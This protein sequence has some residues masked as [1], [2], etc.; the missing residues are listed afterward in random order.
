MNR[1]PNDR[2]ILIT[3]SDQDF[4][5]VLNATDTAQRI[6]GVLPIEAE[7]N[8][9]G[10]EIYF[11]TGVQATK[12]DV[13]QQDMEVGDLAFWPPGNAFCVFWGPTPASTGNIPR[14]ASPVVLIGRLI[15]PDLSALAKTADG[16]SIL[17]TRQ[18]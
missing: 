18:N 5:A 12:S 6:Y 1:E 8:R 13:T 2:R 17:L 9:W 11:G 16:Q 3:V 7:I 15:N 4:N 14:A 10:D